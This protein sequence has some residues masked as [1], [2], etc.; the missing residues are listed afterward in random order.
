MCTGVE[1]CKSALQCLHFQLATFQVFLVDGGY[2]KFA[3][4]AWLD[5]LGY[6]YHAV[7][8]EV[9]SHHGVVA[10]RMFWL[11]LDAE[12]VALCVKLCHTVAF[13]VVHIVAEYC[14]LAVALDVLHAFAQQFGEARTVEYVV[15]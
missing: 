3:T 7:R 1:P 11:L 6:L 4:C 15:A 8:V 2:L 10:L 9:E 5:V 13:R 14:R 12:A